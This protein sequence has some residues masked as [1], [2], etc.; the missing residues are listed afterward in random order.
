MAAL[1]NGVA[2]GRG[3]RVDEIPSWRESRDEGDYFVNAAPGALVY[4]AS[5]AG[6]VAYASTL[7]DVV[8]LAK[9]TIDR[10]VDQ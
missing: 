9:E 8:A 6:Q 1:E 5:F 7:H 10:E 2:Y 3:D 4:M